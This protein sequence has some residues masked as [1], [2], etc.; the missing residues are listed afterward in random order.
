MH[1]QDNEHNKIFFQHDEL[2]CISKFYYVEY[3]NGISWDRL[4]QTE[5]LHY[6]IVS[7]TVKLHF[8]SIPQS[9]QQ[10]PTIL[11]LLVAFQFTHKLS[12]KIAQ[13]NSLLLWEMISCVNE[14]FFLQKKQNSQ[15]VSWRHDV[16]ERKN[17][18]QCCFIDGDDVRNLLVSR[19]ILHKSRIRF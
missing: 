2:S 1:L 10:F 12:S 5:L 7:K 8:F 3:I 6:L 16:L 19:S 4:F 9:H 11:P 14:E 18:L 15:I 13:M 17:S